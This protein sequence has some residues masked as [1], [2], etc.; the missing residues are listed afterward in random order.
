[1]SPQGFGF[2]WKSFFQ[3]STGIWLRMSLYPGTRRTRDYERGKEAFGKL[4][5]FLF[6]GHAQ[7][8]CDLPCSKAQQCAQQAPGLALA[9]KENFPRN[10]CAGRTGIIIQHLPRARASSPQPGLSLLLSEQQLHQ[11][12]PGRFCETQAANCSSQ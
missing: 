9:F 11:A 10:A 1:M 8:G 3:F 2:R 5:D 7:R 6:S 4:G 12:G